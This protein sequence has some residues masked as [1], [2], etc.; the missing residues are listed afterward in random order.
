MTDENFKILIDNRENAKKKF[1]NYYQANENPT[2]SFALYMAYR[3][4]HD[5]LLE[6]YQKLLQKQ[7][8]AA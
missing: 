8:D 3:K 7:D 1:K 5:R 4:E 6:A 2:E